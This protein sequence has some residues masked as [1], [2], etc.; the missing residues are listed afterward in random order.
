MAH[1]VLETSARTW[2]SS[3]TNA[4]C[5]GG[6]GYPQKWKHTDRRTYAFCGSCVGSKPATTVNSLCGI[7]RAMARSTPPA[8]VKM[9]KRS[10]KVYP[11]ETIKT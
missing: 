7:R 3:F 4:L 9:E 10:Y 11:Y 5:D 8:P 2:F 6:G 1:T